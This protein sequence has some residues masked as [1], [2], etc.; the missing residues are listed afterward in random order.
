MFTVEKID[1]NFI[2]EFFIFSFI[3]AGIIALDTIWYNRHSIKEM[4][5][6]ID[7]NPLLQVDKYRQ[8]FLDEMNKL[9]YKRFNILLVLSNLFASLLVVYYGFVIYFIVESLM[10]ANSINYQIWRSRLVVTISV[11]SFYFFISDAL[12]LLATIWAIKL[13]IQHL[14]W[15]IKLLI[16]KR[17]HPEIS[18]IELIKTWYSFLLTIFFCHKLNFSSHIS[19]GFKISNEQQK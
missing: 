5:L 2:E 3:L 18:D 19:L 11:Y 6:N 10:M 8:I 15:F 16:D 13:K 1:S 12:L 17:V 9:R 7:F 14:N 4:F